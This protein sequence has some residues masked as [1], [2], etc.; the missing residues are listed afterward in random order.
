MSKVVI[1]ALIEEQGT[2]YSEAMGADLAK[3]TPQP[4]FHWLLGSI[5]LS[6]RISAK[7]AVEAGLGLKKE[8]LATIKALLASD[9]RA[10][11]RALNVHGYARYDTMTADYIREAAA[12]VDERYGGDL[13]RLRDA[14]GDAAGIEAALREVKGIGTTGASIFCREAQLVWDPLYPR[15]D[16]PA[17]DEAKA[18]GLPTD[19][20]ELAR[21]AGSRAR[22]VRLTAAL[23]RAALEGPAEAVNEA[24]R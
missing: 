6:A 14:G 15:L 5:L 9:K 20:A 17:A 1:E 2:L 3:G 12:L 22:F 19:A 18:L 23:T 10:R 13:R 4:L 16:G 7:N 11:I 8:G 24:G 21:I